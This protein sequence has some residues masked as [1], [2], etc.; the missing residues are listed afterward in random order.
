MPRVFAL[1]SD[2][3]LGEGVGIGDDHSICVKARALDG[4]LSDS[5]DRIA[6]LE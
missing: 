6:K 1:A 5:A 2:G 4:Y 3:Q